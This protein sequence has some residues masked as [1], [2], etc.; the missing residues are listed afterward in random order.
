VTETEVPSAAAVQRSVAEC[1]GG[2]AVEVYT[3]AEMGHSW[4][5][6]AGDARFGEHDSGL[7]ATQVIWAFFA[8]RSRPEAAEISAGQGVP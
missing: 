1:A 4:P 8:T 3:V 5:G 2:S 7:Q 6:G